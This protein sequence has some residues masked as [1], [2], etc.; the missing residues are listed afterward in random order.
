MSMADDTTTMQ[1]LLARLAELERA[2][3]RMSEQ[4]AAIQTE[5]ARSD[6]QKMPSGR[7]NIPEK[8]TESRKRKSRRSLLEKGLGVAA[9]TVGAGALIGINGGTAHADGLEGPTVFAS[10]D[11]QVP[12]TARA[13]DSNPSDKVNAIYARADGYTGI[14]GF[15]DNADFG[16]AGVFG[17]GPYVG[18][19][20][21]VQGA[22]TIP[23]VKVGVYGSGSNRQSLGWV[24]V[25]GESDTSYGTTGIS[26][27]TYTGDLA[28]SGAGIG[29]F[30][31]N[32]NDTHAIGVAADGARGYGTVS[33][34]QESLGWGLLSLGDSA[35][36]IG[37]FCNADTGIYATGTTQ[38]G[39]FNGN[40][41]ITGTLT[42]GGG[43]FKI[44]HPLDPA[45][46]YLSHSFV[47]SPDMKNVYDG[48]VVLDARGE[49]VVELPTW[50]GVLNKEF[51]YQLTPIGA[52]GPN[53]HI[54]QEISQQHFKIAG[55]TAGMK[56]CWQVTGVRQDAWA[57]AHPVVVEQSK[58]AHEQG[59][60]LHPELYGQPSE[61]NVMTARYAKK[62]KQP[63]P[64]SH[65]S[66]SHS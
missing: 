45:N 35:S 16:S 26:Y 37:V 11:T 21:F 19:T 53:L 24:G 8:S 38:A 10:S 28:T 12:V 51:R 15:T 39:F 63:K 41:N 58:A 1:E 40:V 57:Q 43:S 49:A 32:L 50:F 55:G 4:L 22:N 25:E 31:A 2:N 48:T 66:K 42:K 60:Y 64:H 36:G 33:V 14:A 18:V 17:S 56:V 65:W 23:I 47:E 13:N 6:R 34:A 30:T 61:K 3:A 7:A 20:G 54:A 27:G 46:K 62:M 44:D 59:L 9:A 52:A 29:G 5:R